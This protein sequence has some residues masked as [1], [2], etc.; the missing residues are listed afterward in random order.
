MGNQDLSALLKYKVKLLIFSCG[1]QTSIEMCAL[2][3]FPCHLLAV[4]TIEAEM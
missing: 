4:L 2:S 3:G 1:G